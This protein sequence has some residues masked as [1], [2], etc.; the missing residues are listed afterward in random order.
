MKATKTYF[1]YFFKSFERPNLINPTN[2][3]TL[4]RTSSPLELFFDLIFVVIFGALNNILL[5]ST[6]EAF[7][8][9]STL[10]IFIYNLWE[11]VTMYFLRFF[12]QAILLD[13]V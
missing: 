2:N 13:L 3:S 7:F 8:L 10:F 4:E 1:T 6:I 9:F 12:Q 5:N 11:N